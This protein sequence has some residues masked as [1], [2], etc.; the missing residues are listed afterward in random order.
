MRAESPRYLLFNRYRDFL[1]DDGR[2]VRDVRVIG[3]NELE[4][5]LA[6]RQLEHRLCLAFA[7]V[8]ADLGFIHR[9]HLIHGRHFVGV[10]ENVMMAGV[11][12]RNAIGRGDAGWAN[13][14]AFQAE[15]DFEL[16][17][18]RVAILGGDEINAG[19]FGG[20]LAL[21]FLGGNDRGDYQNGKDRTTGRQELL[22]RWY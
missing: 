22:H 9:Q 6:G 1:G 12:I 4:G 5:V 11:R 7:E 18:H 21:R 19:S 17:L 13:A 14:H 2:I 16:S 15:L 20:R 8:Q 10:Q 3:E